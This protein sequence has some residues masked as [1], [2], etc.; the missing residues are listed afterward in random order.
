MKIKSIKISNILTFENYDD[1]DKAPEISFD[2]KLNIL[3]G[4]NAS[5]KSN[6]LD[7]VDSILKSILTLGCT[8]NEGVITAH[9]Q[10]PQQNPI[11]RVLV[12][13]EAYHNLLPNHA[14]GIKQQKIKIKL[15]LEEDDFKNLEFIIKEI[16]KINQLL[17]KY[18][19]GIS[20]FNENVTI[21]QVKKI[22]VVEFTFSGNAE[23]KSMNLQEDFGNNE[24][25]RFI[26]N[27]FFLFEFLQN[28]ILIANR[29]EEE[30]WPPLHMFRALISSYRNYDRIVDNYPVQPNE[31]EKLQPI[32]NKVLQES[33]RKS[34]E[35]EPPIFELTRHKLSYQ[36]D[37]IEN[38]MVNAKITNTENKTSLEILEDV[39]T[40]YKEI[41]TLL[42]LHLKLR[43]KVHRREK[44]N[45]YVFSFI[46]IESNSI[47]D[48][49]ELSSGEKG[50]IH[51]I[52]SLYG[53]EIKN[54]V[55]VIDEPELHLHPQMQNKYLDVIDTVR[56]KLGIQF[57]F[58]THS[59]VFITSKTIQSVYRFYKQNG[60][61]K[62]VKPTINEP[63][64]DLIHFLTFTNSSKIFFADKVVLVEGDKDHY[65]FQ[66]YLNDYKTR[67]NKE[68]ANIEFLVINGKGE[69]EKWKNFLNKYKIKTFYI[70]D[71]DNLLENSISSYASTWKASYGD[72]LRQA[73]I[74]MIKNNGTGDYQQMISEI[75]K[76]YS[77]NLFLLCNG[78]LEDNLSNVIGHEPKFGDVIK[79]CRNNFQT[80]ITTNDPLIDQADY[81]MRYITM[82]IS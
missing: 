56:N 52:F 4:T 63:E 32:Y 41:N 28:V 70:G 23:Q 51:F 43:L 75:A 19:R 5:G 45:E 36:L 62:I 54:G 9:A 27:Y 74:N 78:S 12:K 15:E 25:L 30:N 53:Y 2:E 46:N 58:A 73:E 21:D 65:F 10:N 55:M 1:I 37:N 38:R 29:F 49:F 79:F 61:T 35:K 71:F 14:S 13:R 42:K 16:K 39:S 72:K 66:Y 57:I 69:F 22:S 48:V 18:G 24:P 64:R 50:L 8:F 60:I 68:I 59:P 77:E 40:I 76:K 81:F 26:F 47:V 17:Q 20:I 80:W 7:I 33:T 44:S 3:I 11:N 6:F 67:K 82:K 34:E 31:F